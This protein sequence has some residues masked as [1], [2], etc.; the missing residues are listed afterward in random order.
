MVALKSSGELRWIN[1]SRIRLSTT[2]KPYRP[3]P[4]FTILPDIKSE[5]LLAH[6]CESLASASVMLNDFATYLNGPQ[7]NTALGIAQIVML[8]EL[9][10][11]RA[12]DNV[13]PQG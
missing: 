7:R 2:D 8:A 10:V 9:A 5:S 1:L 13:D 3:S 4:F 6:A 11:N 12:L